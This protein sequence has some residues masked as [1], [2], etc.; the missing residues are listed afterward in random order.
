MNAEN[1]DIFKAKGELDFFL[2]DN[3]ELKR[4]TFERPYY[5]SIH[6]KDENFVDWLYERFFE[7]ETYSIF[8]GKEFGEMIDTGYIIDYDGTLAD[9]FVDGFVSNLGLFHNGSNL[10]ITGI[11]SSFGIKQ[12]YLAEFRNIP[13]K[14]STPRT[15]VS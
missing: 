1:Q 7:K 10:S 11:I 13:L 9:V 6:N 5:L 3:G 12:K 8:T 14:V 15:L 4:I 2:A